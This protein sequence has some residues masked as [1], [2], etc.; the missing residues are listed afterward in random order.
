LFLLNVRFS[1]PGLYSVLSLLFL[2][3]FVFA[4][5]S[6]N[7]FG[8]VK[9]G[10]YLDNVRRTLAISLPAAEIDFCSGL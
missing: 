10:F 8:T 9:H 2:L 3:F 7:L 4:I 6:M 1:L 5:A